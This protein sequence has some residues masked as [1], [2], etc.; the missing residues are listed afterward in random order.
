MAKDNTCY[1]VIL[2]I[3]SLRPGSGYDI[4]K[5][6]EYGIGYFYKVSNGQVYPVLKKLMDE[7]HVTCLIQ[8]NEGKPDRKTY[9]ITESGLRVF[10]NWLETPA[11][12]NDGEMLLKLYFGSIEPI[13]YNIELLTHIKEVK[14]KQ[15][16]AYEEIADRFDTAAR[17]HLSNYYSYFTLRFGQIMTQAYIDWSQEVI[18]TLREFDH[19]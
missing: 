11:F 19:H 4:K 18:D 9:T 8:K 10:K 14:V 13:K 15:Q 5:T 12:A 7:N 17:A 16:V 2:G 1:Y 3:L 6:I